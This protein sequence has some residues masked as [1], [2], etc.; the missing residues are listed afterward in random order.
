MVQ[1]GIARSQLESG[2]QTEQCLSRLFC[3]GLANLYNVGKT[4]VAIAKMRRKEIEEAMKLL[5]LETANNYTIAPPRCFMSCS[6]A[7]VPGRTL[8]TETVSESEPH[9]SELA[10]GVF[11]GCVYVQAAL[12]AAASLEI[13]N[14][15][16]I[17]PSSRQTPLFIHVSLFLSHCS[18]VAAFSE[19]N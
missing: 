8:K 1:L 19:Y 11:G 13:E 16:G 17:A 7:W 18:H 6:P 3:T 14:S 2:Y 9:P 15:T 5:H 10:I 4:R 12:A